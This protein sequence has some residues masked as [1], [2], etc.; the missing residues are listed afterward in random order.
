MGAAGAAIY[1]WNAMVST[2]CT[3]AYTC[4]HKVCTFQFLLFLGNKPNTA[5]VDL[6]SLD[7]PSKIFL[8][9][10]FLTVARS[11]DQLRLYE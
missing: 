8:R 6:H 9:A 2:T 7:L 5:C 4:S 1:L 3:D 11:I 10:F